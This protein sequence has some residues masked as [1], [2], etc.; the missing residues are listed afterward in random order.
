[1]KHLTEY[2]NEQLLQEA[3]DDVKSFVDKLRKQIN[4]V[5]NKDPKNISTNDFINELEKYVKENVKGAD[6]SRNDKKN[7]PNLTI[8]F[9]NGQVDHIDI[10]LPNKCIKGK[11]TGDPYVSCEVSATK[12]HNIS[13]NN[14]TYLNLNGEEAGS[15]DEAPCTDVIL[16]KLKLAIQGFA[17][18]DNF[19]DKAFTKFKKVKDKVADTFYSPGG[20]HSYDSSK[21]KK[22]AV[23]SAAFRL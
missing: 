22:A 1:M 18:V 13:G 15:F 9:D 14:Y 21:R 10:L 23:M 17:R 16:A 3:T 20:S 12:E 5:E 19:F 7:V 4:K 6:C 11:F 2:I 8:T